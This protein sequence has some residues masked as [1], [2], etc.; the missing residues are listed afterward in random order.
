M[1]RLLSSQETRV[2]LSLFPPMQDFKAS[3]DVPM[4]YVKSCGVL[5][6]VASSVAQ[7]M[8]RLCSV[9]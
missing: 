4:Q 7:A 6:A 1:I 5:F 9:C 8:L 3:A 2:A